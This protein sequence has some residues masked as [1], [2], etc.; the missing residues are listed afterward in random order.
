MEK[1]SDVNFM[2]DYLVDSWRELT[3]YLLQHPDK[4]WEGQANYW[5]S[6]SKISED[7]SK[8]FKQ[9]DKRFQAEHW[10][11]YLVYNFIQRS[12]LLLSQ[13]LQSF[14]AT[15]DEKDKA[16]KKLR[17]FA[18][19]FVSA[20]SPSNFIH[21][22]PEILAQ[23]W[24]TNGEN[25][26]EGFKQFQYD[27]Q[28]GKNIFQ[29]SN[30]D[31][32][33]FKIGQNI[34]CT[35]GKV[36]YQNDLMQLIQY[37]PS[38][39]K[40]YSLPLLMIPPWINKYYILDLQKENSLVKWLVDQGFMVFMISW[41]NPSTPQQNKSFDEYLFLGP[42][43]ALESIQ[44]I[45]KATQIN[46]LGYC[47]GG[48][49][50]GCLLSYLAQK[51][52]SHFVASA[53]FLTTLFDFSSPG[54]LAIFVDEAQI[55]MLD[56]H[57]QDKGYLDGKILASVFST[58]RANDLVWSAFVNNYLKGQKPKP[59]DLL[60]WN[61]DAT[62]VPAALHHFYLR[63]M[64]LNN[65]LIAKKIHIENITLDLNQITIPSYFLAAHDD[66]IIPWQSSYHGLHHLNGPVKFVL[67]GSGHVAAVVNPPYKKRYGYWLNDQVS[68]SAEDFL[69][70]AIFQ[71]GSWWLDWKQWLEKYSGQLIS[72]QKSSYPNEKYIEDA[73]GSYVKVTL[74]DIEEKCFSKTY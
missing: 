34:A 24:Q 39:E 30:N 18:E 25:L 65:D 74:D 51:A 1:H 23:V 9:Q 44:K 10:Q 64:Y 57:M 47:V 5:Q 68:L 4:L 56:K 48:T 7:F 29:I 72:P 19:Q 70:T 71:P 49:L 33:F 38:T 62:N 26:L 31:K 28:Q 35:P 40:I 15:F 16:A 67:A 20:M 45:T 14:S 46:M 58:L 43:C 37:I 59:F 11:N 13:H 55:S 54:E 36:V 3:T 63:H 27:L 50:L 41:V 2:M 17:F 66:H 6:Y 42:L 60:F 69:K 22:N 61:A 73:P 8:D 52:K 21:T 12:Y 32:N 53:T